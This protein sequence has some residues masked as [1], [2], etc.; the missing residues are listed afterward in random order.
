MHVRVRLRGFCWGVG[1]DSKRAQSGTLWGTGNILL[2]LT[3]MTWKHWLHENRRLFTFLQ[4]VRVQKPCLKNNWVN[5]RD[6]RWAGAKS[7][8]QRESMATKKQR[9]ADGTIPY[10]DWG[11][12][13][14]SVCTYQNSNTQKSEF[15]RMR[16]VPQ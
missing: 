11:G 6:N 2:H 15:L 5:Y 12:S 7:W 8:G 13:H 3:G 10:T 9:K 14:T 16:T 1:E 4:Y